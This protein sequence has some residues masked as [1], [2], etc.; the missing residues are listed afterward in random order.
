MKTLFT[1]IFLLLLL[2]TG[3]LSREALSNSWGKVN[4]SDVHSCQEASDEPTASVIRGAN[5]MVSNGFFYQWEK[6]ISFALSGFIASPRPISLFIE[7]PVISQYGVLGKIVD[8]GKTNTETNALRTAVE[9]PTITTG[10]ISTDNYYCP[11]M[12]INVSFFV[13]SPFNSDN[14]FTIQLSDANGSFASPVNL[15][16]FKSTESGETTVFPPSY[17]NGAGY[18]IRVVASS[19]SVIGSVNEGGAI[20]IFP[21]KDYYMDEDGDGHFSVLPLELCDPSFYGAYQIFPGDDCDDYDASIHPRAEDI[22]DGKD[23]DCDGI[24]DN[25]KPVVIAVANAGSVRMNSS[26]SISVY[27]G[28][29]GTASYCSPTVSASVLSGQLQ[30]NSRQLNEYAAPDKSYYDYTMTLAPAVVTSSA[31]NINLVPFDFSLQ[32]PELYYSYGQLHIL[33]DF[34]QDGI[35][36]ESEKVYDDRVDVYGG[37]ASANGFLDIPAGLNLVTRMRVLLDFSGSVFYD[38]CSG[39]LILDYPVA[40]NPPYTY[41][42]S[43]STNLSS[44]TVADPYISTINKTTTYSVTVTDQETGCTSQSSVTV[45]VLSTPPSITTQPANRLTYAGEGAAFS[46]GATGSNLMYQWQESR[47]GGSTFASVSNG[48]VYSGATTNTLYLTNVPVSMHSYQYRVVV[49]N[50]VETLSNAATLSVREIDPAT[51]PWEVVGTPNFSQGVA[52]RTTFALAPDGTPYVAFVD[53]QEE[54]NENYELVIMKYYGGSWVKV[55]STKGFEGSDYYTSFDNVWNIS[56]AFSADGTPYVGFAQAGSSQGLTVIKYNGSKWAAV[57]GSSFPS[58]G[59]GGYLSLVIAPDN[60]PYIAYQELN[61]NLNGDFAGRITVRKYNGSSW[62]VVGVRGFSTWINDNLKMVMAPNGELYVAF[63]DGKYGGKA[64]VMKY[65]GSAWEVVGTSGFSAGVIA[66]VSLA[67]SP[68]G[69]PYVAYRGDQSNGQ[70]ATVMKYTGSSWEL[71][72]PQGFSEG[73]TS[74]P[75]L[76]VAQDGTPF[77]AYFDYAYTGRATVMKYDGSSWVAVGP[78]GFSP[79]DAHHASLAMASNG[80]LYLGYQNRNDGVYGSKV[81]VMKF[82]N[83][84]TVATPPSITTQP[85]AK[86]ITA[87]QSTSFTVGASGEGAITYQ[88]QVSQD[89]GTTFANISNGG[90]YGGATNDTLL[91]SNVPL[92]MNGYWYRVVVSSGAEANSGAA[93]LTV[94]ALVSDAVVSTKPFA[95]SNLVLTSVSDTVVTLNWADNSSNETSFKV[96]RSLVPEF[97]RDTVVTIVAENITSY[98][99]TSVVKDASYYFKILSLNDSGE[100]SSNVQ[101]LN[102]TCPPDLQFKDI[103]AEYSTISINDTLTFKPSSK[104]VNTAECAS[105][106]SKSS[107]K[108][109]ISE[110]EVLDVVEDINISGNGFETEAPLRNTSSA[111]FKS[112]K[113]PDS[114]ALLG[115]RYLIFQLDPE[116]KIYEKNETNNLAV[117]PIFITKNAGIKIENFEISNTNQENGMVTVNFDV[118]NTGEGALGE[119]YIDFR[120]EQNRIDLTR[121]SGLDLGQRKSISKALPISCV[122]YGT[123][124]LRVILNPA[125]NYNRGE[126]SYIRKEILLNDTTNTT[127]SGEYTFVGT[128]PD[129]GIYIKI[130]NVRTVDAG[131]SITVESTVTNTGVLFEGTQEINYYLSKNDTLDASD[132][133]IGHSRFSAMLVCEG[134]TIITE[135]LTIPSTA[136]LGDYYVLAKVDPRSGLNEINEE[137]NT[138]ARSLVVSKN[139]DLVLQS[140]TISNTSPVANERTRI[141]FSIKNQGQGPVSDSYLDVYVSDDD[142][143]SPSTDTRLTSY[144]EEYNWIHIPSLAAGEVYEGSFDLK[145]SSC[146]IEG[147]KFVFAIADGYFPN[148]NGNVIPEI[149]ETN[150]YNSS[151]VKAAI[152]SNPDLNLLEPISGKTTSTNKITASLNIQ[153]VGSSVENDSQLKFY[154]SDDLQLSS[155]D[156]LLKTITINSASLACKQTYLINNLEIV[157]PANIKL[158]TYKVLIFADADSSIVEQSEENN[159]NFIVFEKIVGG[160]TGPVEPTPGPEPLSITTSALAISSIRPGIQFEVPYEKTGTYER[161][162][163]EF[164]VELSDASGSFA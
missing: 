89:A 96:V 127:A 7:P 145:F 8:S 133:P 106:A 157:L 131:G 135:V 86:T 147:D 27:T 51:N 62:D 161:Y 47:D 53:S 151:G 33:I 162:V 5:S 55:G 91:L 99:D 105:Y 141:N 108:V 87:G 60:T 109:Y 94:N 68:D 138:H 130:K 67:L 110:D 146:G 153:N 13:S 78:L 164:R 115:Q 156:S 81:T 120:S 28:S 154:L 132:Q 134:E 92:E 155:S 70:K 159:F 119:Y 29:I 25:G 79:D 128:K 38:Y 103:V 36:E 59:S 46:V 140:F 158:G 43:P 12:P 45:E 75:S 113:I 107:Y 10:F 3:G 18:Q 124:N 137:N 112:V 150:N 76:V 116:N 136:A 104:I 66:D 61:T 69:L 22:C 24:V 114:I 17:A 11:G 142:N 2:L 37:G 50:G 139:P 123:K 160:T 35:F 163:N 117:V 52:N 44:A 30:L 65:N 80:T 63:Q 6:S 148:L 121:E 144:G 72:G 97:D 49:S 1:K 40:I 21:A 16:T 64:S 20:R 84:V 32:T 143:F 34:N 77:V 48:G 83:A 14:V 98:T 19:P 74:S 23:N 56:I 54:Y 88:W 42:W 102:V 39:D 93:L 73:M 100:A 101:A 111:L 9:T 152:K 31:D 125:L 90:V 122:N 82:A 26:S 4:V 118:V 57:G 58:E 129:L 149:N 71:V 85:V 126:Y 95:P 41:S 15:D